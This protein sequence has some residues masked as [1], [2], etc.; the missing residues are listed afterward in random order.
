MYTKKCKVCGKEFNTNNKDYESC[1]R[2]CA[3]ISRRT[4]IYGRG[5]NDYNGNVKINNKHINSYKVWRCMFNRCYAKNDLP[6]IRAYKDAEVCK[7]WW[8]YSIF[9]EWYNEHYID[10]N[11][12]DKDICQITQNKMYCPQNCAFIPKPLN[13]LIS[14]SG[15]KSKLPRGIKHYDNCERFNVT[16]CKFKKRIVVGNYNT[17][18]EAKRAYKSAKESYIKEVAQ[19]YYDAGKIEKKVYDSLMNWKI[20]IDD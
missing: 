13:N 6:H 18:Y 12:L 20:N 2:G 10:G 14:L 9:L 16:I 11:V 7:E 1:N 8:S 4:P 19:E 15:V 3:D 17:L 5:I